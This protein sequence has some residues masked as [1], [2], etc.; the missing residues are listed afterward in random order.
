VT[1]LPSAKPKGWL[2]TNPASAPLEP[3]ASFRARV[4]C[5]AAHCISETRASPTNRARGQEPNGFGA[6]AQGS[7]SSLQHE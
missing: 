1:D 2:T 7:L 6:S 4:K 3:G 5:R